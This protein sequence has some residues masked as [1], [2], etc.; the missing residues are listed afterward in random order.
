MQALRELIHDL[1]T[2]LAPNEQPRE[3]G[4][5]TLCQ[6]IISILEMMLNTSEIA[7]RWLGNLG[8]PLDRLA[9]EPGELQE[10]GV[11]PYVERIRT[12]KKKAADE[13]APV[14]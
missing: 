14:Q 6:Q 8:T 4:Q 3:W 7:Q 1:R 5:I 9:T 13:W 2:M 10:G 11:E 12:I